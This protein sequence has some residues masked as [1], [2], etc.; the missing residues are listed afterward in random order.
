L[1]RRI[2]VGCVDASNTSNC[3]WGV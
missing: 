3:L 2:C 1:E